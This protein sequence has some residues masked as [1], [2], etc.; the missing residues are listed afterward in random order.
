MT[1][2]L[3]GIQYMNTAC[4]YRAGLREMREGG[5]RVVYRKGEMSGKRGEGG[6]YI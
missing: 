3:L 5:R 6:V 1:S 2:R 4:T